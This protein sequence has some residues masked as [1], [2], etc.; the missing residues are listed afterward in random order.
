MGLIGKVTADK[1]KLKARY[2]QLDVDIWAGRTCEVEKRVFDCGKL[3]GYVLF[4]GAKDSP[5]G[6][7]GDSLMFD[8]DLVELKNNDITEVTYGPEGKTETRA[9]DDLPIA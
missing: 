3:T 1:K 5:Y 7:L 9:S 8:A 6:V 2:P 4:F